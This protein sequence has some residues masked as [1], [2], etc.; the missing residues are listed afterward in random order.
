MGIFNADIY[1]I[2]EINQALKLKIHYAYYDNLET[3]LQT[4]LGKS[5]RSAVFDK[6]KFTKELAE[7][8]LKERNIPTSDILEDEKS[9]YLG[10]R[11]FS[12]F[13]ESDAF[14]R[15]NIEEGIDLLVKF[16]KPE[17]LQ[18][19]KEEREKALKVH[20]FVGDICVKV[21]VS[22]EQ[23]VKDLGVVLGKAFLTEEEARARGK[24]A[25]EKNVKERDG[26]FVAFDSEGNELGVFNTKEE[27]AKVA[28]EGVAKSSN[29]K[30]IKN[31][32]GVVEFDITMPIEKSEDEGIVVGIVYRPGVVDLQGDSASAE[33]IAKACY[34]FNVES[35][36]LG[37]MHKA[38]AGDRATILESYLSPA[39]FKLGSGYVT[40]GTWLMSI[41]L[42]DP[43]LKKAVKE[44]KLTGLSMSGQARSAD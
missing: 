34:K 31:I 38:E 3:F 7:K 32:D 25:L 42:N 5:I 9:F 19:L 36:T 20:N 27:A 37:I 14:D 21:D 12:D 8:W 24:E 15:V 10:L 35:K 17:I 26:K 33:E 43:E 13:A 1:P 28:Y 30:V 2:A 40:K 4:K 44:N 16:V 6:S 23:L 22:A 39:N 29:L 41:R 18:I 11:K